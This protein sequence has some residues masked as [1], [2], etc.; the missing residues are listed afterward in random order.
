MSIDNASEAVGTT[1]ASFMSLLPMVAIFAIFYFFLIRPQVK[2]QKEVTNML[3][4]L[5]K[6]D[7][8][9]A[10]GGLHGTIYKID[11]NVIYLEIA[12]N[13]KIQASKSSV[14]EILSRNENALVKPRAKAKPK[15]PAKP[16]TTTK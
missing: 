14:T 10:A 1:G 2:R 8:V 11:E 7:K 4:E 15:A 9:V 3:S 16:K 13:V 12:E 6:G 5:K